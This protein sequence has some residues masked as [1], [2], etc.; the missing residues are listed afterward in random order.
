MAL[1]DIQTNS[2]PGKLHLEQLY[3]NG[4]K[5][6]PTIKAA[7][8]SKGRWLHYSPKDNK[9]AI[10]KLWPRSPTTSADSNILVEKCSKRTGLPISWYSWGSDVIE[11]S[12]NDIERVDDVCKAFKKEGYPISMIRY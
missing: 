9:I 12:A 2:N 5:K 1:D 11:I 10:G 8:D 7:V 3:L 4:D 6:Y